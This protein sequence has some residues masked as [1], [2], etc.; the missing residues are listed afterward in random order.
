MDGKYQSTLRF[1]A[2]GA[3][4]A[5]IRTIIRQTVSWRP[6]E[7]PREGYTIILG[8]VAGLAEMLPSNLKCLAAQD[9]THLREI[10]IVFDRPP[11]QLAM[12]VEKAVKERFPQLPCRFV[13]YSLFQRAVTKAIGW[14][15]VDLWLSWCIGIAETTT[16]YAFLH[17]FDAMLINPRFIEE[18]YEQISKRGCEYLGV[19]FYQDLNGHLAEDR[20]VRTFEMF[21]DA[22]FLR[23][24]RKPIDTFNHLQQFDGRRVDFDTFMYAQWKGGKREVIPS[25]P[26]DMVHPSQLIC[27]FAFHSVGSRRLTL[28]HHSLMLIPYFVSVGGEPNRMRDLTQQMRRGNG[29]K[30]VQFYGKDLDLG[31]LDRVHVEWLIQLATQLDRAV[32]DQVRPEVSQYLEAFDAF[33]RS[34]PASAT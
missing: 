34:A 6:I 22:E 26:A 33:T 4:R 23:R 16:Q 17:D 2:V 18:R 20:L 28:T 32:F 29:E 30:L 25:S 31:R 5:V 21:F 10:I 13:H 24:T 11:R 14:A 19:G 12:D 7:N 8:C 1:R 27:Q 9:L 3:Y 15:W